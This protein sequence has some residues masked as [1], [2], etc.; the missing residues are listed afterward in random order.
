MVLMGLWL[1]SQYDRSY[2]LITARRERK[3]MAMDLERRLVKKGGRRIVTGYRNGKSVVIDDAE[4]PAQD[5]LGAKVVE[6]WETVG[7]PVIPL[8]SEKY[9]IPL[10]FKMP[11]S[12]ETRLRL[13]VIPPDG[14]HGAGSGMHKTKTIDYD[15]ILFGELW[16]EMDDGVEVRL[17]PGDCVIQNGTRHAWHNRSAENCIMLTMCIGGKHIDD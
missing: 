8:E 7:T 1:C 17:N 9:K 6:L 4:V 15:T 13:T 5:L 16:M 2:K 12:G 14:E 11:A 10:T 3:L